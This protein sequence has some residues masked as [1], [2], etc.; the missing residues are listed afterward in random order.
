M[1]VAANVGGAWVA[2]TSGRP[3]SVAPA[4]VLG[5][6]PNQGVEGTITAPSGSQSVCIWAAPTNGPAVMLDCRTVSVP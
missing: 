3:S 2:L 4:F 1:P 5:A 6:G